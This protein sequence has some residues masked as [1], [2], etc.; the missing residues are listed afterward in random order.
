LRLSICRLRWGGIRHVRGAAG[1]L[2]RG[3]RSQSV[4]CVRP[5]AWTHRKKLATHAVSFCGIEPARHALGHS[6]GEAKGR[7]GVIVVV[8]SAPARVRSTCSP[9][10]AASPPSSFHFS[11]FCLRR[12]MRLECRERSAQVKFKNMRNRHVRYRFPHFREKCAKCTIR[13]PRLEMGAGGLAG[14]QI[15]PAYVITQKGNHSTALVLCL[16]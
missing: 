16:C 9:A 10:A 13:S 2:L 15:W 12:S 4:P 14:H 3:W 7:H 8:Q 6:H 11:I 1:E 5:V